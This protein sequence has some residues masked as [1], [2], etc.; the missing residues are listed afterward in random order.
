MEPNLA[1]AII[2]H[3]AGDYLL[4]NDW[5]SREKKKNSG[6]CALHAGLWTL[7]V[8]F[9]GGLWSWWAVPFLFVT[10]FLQDRTNIISCWMS[11]LGQHHFK[12]GPCSPWSIIV[13]DNTWHLLMV[14]VVWKLLPIWN[15]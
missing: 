8:C 13:V 14:W 6:V 3:L 1:A 9:F 7:A 12:T 2:G 11:G 15:F 4:Q 5:M 10:H